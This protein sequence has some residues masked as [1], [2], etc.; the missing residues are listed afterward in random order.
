MNIIILIFLTFYLFYLVLDPKGFL[1]GILIFNILVDTI[2]GFVD[3]GE[4]AT[5]DVLA[6]GRA[7][8]TIIFLIIY[9]KFYFSTLIKD[10]K[11]IFLFFILVLILIPF[12]SKIITSLNGSI[13]IIITYSMLPI[14]FYFF[15]TRKALERLNN[16]L[17]WVIFF[18]VIN[19]ILA[20]IFQ[21]GHTSYSKYAEFYAGG[22]H[23]G[24]LNTLALCL[25]LVMF[26][27]KSIDIK[28]KGMLFVLIP[29]LLI[30]LVLSMKRAPIFASFLGLIIFFWYSKVKGTIIKIIL[31]F[32]TLIILAYP[33]Y[34]HILEEQL[35]SRE[36]QLQINVIEKEKRY[37]EIGMV[38][39][40]IIYSSDLSIFLFG[41]EIFNTIG[42]Y[43][44][45]TFG[46]RAL[47]T[48]IALIL[49]STGI[50]GF[51]LFIYI[52][53]F[54]FNKFRKLE[55]NADRF[56]SQDDILYLSLKPLFYS[57]FIV[58]LAISFS[59]G[60]LAVTYRSVLFIYLGAIMGTYENILKNNL[61]LKAK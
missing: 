39:D 14:G 56:I 44:G 61:L 13:K 5:N 57:L 25:I 29:L 3:P 53:F 52:Y 19:F 28:K 12:S 60:I 40:D 2:T 8:I 43:A 10:F 59:E 30:F 45:G 1:N 51:V 7:I 31:A 11:P 27:Y 9:F 33:F 46:P 26:I 18:V 54:I 35:F 32:A 37:L 48:D 15:K 34:A 21:I 55:K 49:N 24:A 58:S 20:N 6:V 38:T 16:S 41:K 23:V 36:K 47:H 42:N 4:T 22:F 17:F 50:I